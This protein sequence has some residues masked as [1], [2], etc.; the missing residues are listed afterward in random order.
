MGKHNTK[1]LSEDYIQKCMELIGPSNQQKI[2]GKQFEETYNRLINHQKKTDQ[3]LEE[4]RR[5]IRQ[6]EKKH[7]TFLPNTQKPRTRKN[8]KKRLENRVGNILESKNQKVQRLK[9]KQFK[10]EEELIKN[11]CSFNPK[12]NTKKNR[13]SSVKDSTSQLER[14]QRGK[15]PASQLILDELTHHPEE[16]EYSFRPEISQKSRQ[17]LESRK[18]D[19][20]LRNVSDRLYSMGQKS[21]NIPVPENQNQKI[22]NQKMGKRGSKRSG[23]ISRIR[24]SQSRRLVP[25]GSSTSRIPTQDTKSR[26]KHSISKSN[27]GDISN[28]QFKDSSKMVLVKEEEKITKNKNQ[29]FTNHAPTIRR[30]KSV[31]HMKTPVPQS[32]D[33]SPINKSGRNGKNSKISKQ[34]KDEFE[35]EVDS[36]I[37]VE[38]DK[39]NVVHAN[40]KRSY[41]QRVN[42][43]Q[44]NSKRNQSRPKYSNKTTDIKP[45]E[46]GKKG[47]MFLEVSGGV[48]IYF[49]EEDVGSILDMNLRSKLLG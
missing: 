28:I 20:C 32:F 13:S 2:S 24:N 43:L 38:E 8:S 15:T 16:M 12:L 41:K 27:I 17:I 19:S 5:H 44:K 3:E 45:K 21:M 23:S 49:Q 22:Q 14:L 1:E 35:I 37:L 36:F 7:L 4:R 9:M 29:N 6:R 39:E 26:R 42:N 10:E 31:N 48:K 46:K 18:L 47:R 11:E 40:N 30:K 33:Y 34:Q 25:S